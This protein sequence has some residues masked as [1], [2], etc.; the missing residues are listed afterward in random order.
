MPWVLV[1][2]VLGAVLASAGFGMKEC[3]RCGMYSAAALN[4]GGIGR[5]ALSSCS[6]SNQAAID[7][8]R[9]RPAQQHAADRAADDGTPWTCKLVCLCDGPVPHRGADARHSYSTEQASSHA[10]VIP[11]IPW[12]TSQATPSSVLQT[13]G[14]VD[15]ESESILAWPSVLVKKAKSIMMAEKYP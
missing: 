9:R 4:V 15:G 1:E 3:L 10:T 11:C 14:S 5:I 8:D 7:A 6:C 13:P 12:H 2:A